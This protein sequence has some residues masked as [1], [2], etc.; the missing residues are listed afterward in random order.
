MNR[1]ALY[2]WYGKEY[3]FEEKG[4][5][6]YWALGIIALAAIVACILFNSILLAF[7]VLAAASTLALSVAKHPRTHH[8]MIFDIGVGIDNSLYLYQ[9]MVDFSILEYL[10]ETF[11]P[12]LSI[13]TNRILAPHILI[14]IVD[15]DPI[16]IYEYI[17]LHL[18]EGMHENSVMDRLVS[19]LKL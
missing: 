6:W 3:V 2:E 15:H 17:S 4:A 12:A 19:L 11:P 1:T 18:P 5:D 7:V 16:E 9:D 8:F 10:D 14:P 13:K